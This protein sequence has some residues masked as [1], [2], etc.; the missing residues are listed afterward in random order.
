MIELESDPGSDSAPRGSEMKIAY[1]IAI[2]AAI[3]S[4]INIGAN[5]FRDRE[6]VSVNKKMTDYSLYHNKVLKETLVQGER[7]LLEDLVRAGA[8]IPKDTSIIH[9]RLRKFDRELD[10]IRY[11]QAEIMYGSK[12]Q[13]PASWSMPDLSNKLGNI[14]GLVLWEHEVEVLDVAGDKFDLSCLLLEL[15]LVLGA[16]GFLVKMAE[17]RNLFRWLMIIFGTIGI[18]FGMVGYYQALSI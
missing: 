11:Q 7:D 4:F 8:I 3:L 12:A 1:F 2:F 6:I 14:K 15:S 9:E 17:A 10:T 16:M 13:E 18:G 5:N